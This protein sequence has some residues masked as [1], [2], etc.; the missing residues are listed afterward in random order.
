MTVRLTKGLSHDELEVILKP[1][2][3]S[4]QGVFNHDCL[5]PIIDYVSKSEDQPKELTLIIQTDDLDSK[6]E[7]YQAMYMDLRHGC[8][9]VE[10]FY[11]Y[12]L[13]PIQEGTRSLMEAV[14]ACDWRNNEHEL[15]D[16]LDTKSVACGYHF[17]IY[18]L[19]KTLLQ[20]SVDHI[21]T[22]YS[23]EGC[24][25]EDNDTFAVQMGEEIYKLHKRQ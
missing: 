12:G 16:I 2:I 1:V 10:F 22:I 13:I 25:Q 21:N 23:N 24:N 15:Q 7:R 19:A 6:G 11:S 8:R 20:I 4:Y 18:L 5:K 14:K 3:A 17:A 9:H